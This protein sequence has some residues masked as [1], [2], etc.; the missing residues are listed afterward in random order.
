M[1][2]SAPR[3]DEA[4]PVSRHVEGL[5][6]DADGGRQIASDAVLDGDDRVSDPRLEIDTPVDMPAPAHMP[7]SGTA[8]W[9]LV[10]PAQ[11]GKARE[12][13][14]SQASQRK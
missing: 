1:V 5:K 14:P 11:L 10:S 2:G 4:H 13:R 12:M 3:A 6:P 8:G 7:P 9:S